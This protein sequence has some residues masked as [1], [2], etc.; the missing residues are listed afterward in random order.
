MIS[1]SWIPDETEKSKA[2]LDRSIAEIEI[3]LD[4]VARSVV[5]FV[6]A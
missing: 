1:E 2:N 3:A 6:Q 4:C 5:D